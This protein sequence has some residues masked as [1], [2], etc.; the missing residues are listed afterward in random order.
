MYKYFL[1]DIVLN[2]NLPVAIF[3]QRLLLKDIILKECLDI[4]I[5]LFLC[6]FVEVPNTVFV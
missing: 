6:L 1:V 3:F 2:S 5:S 4:Y